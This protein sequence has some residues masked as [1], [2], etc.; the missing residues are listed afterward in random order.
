M[1]SSEGQLSNKFL[2]IFL[3]VLRVGEVLWTMSAL[4][5][6]CQAFHRSRPWKWLQAKPDQ[7]RR[8]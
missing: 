1:R 5:V 6:G 3:G 7:H 8:E 4:K 2:D